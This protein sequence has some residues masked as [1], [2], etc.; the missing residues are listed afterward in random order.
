MRS[1]LFLSITQVSHR[2]AACLSVVQRRGALAC[3]SAAAASRDRWGLW[4]RSR[5]GPCRRRAGGVSGTGLLVHVATFPLAPRLRGGAGS[6]APAV[7]GSCKRC[8]KGETAQRGEHP[9]SC[10]GPQR[11]G[12]FERGRAGEG[13][14]GIRQRER[15]SRGP[16]CL[17][18]LS[19]APRVWSTQ[20]FR[21]L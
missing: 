19:S 9:P 18:L 6:Q 11:L 21:V 7:L 8:G 13:G 3:G 1:C 20:E 2:M 16:V 5:P 12:P 17:D 10:R 14:T 15:G 4:A